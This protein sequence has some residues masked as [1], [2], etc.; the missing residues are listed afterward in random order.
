MEAGIQKMMTTEALNVEKPTEEKGLDPEVVFETKTV[1][2]QFYD[3]IKAN[4]Q[5]YND[6]Q[7]IEELFKRSGVVYQEGLQAKLPQTA[8]KY[9]NLVGSAFTILMRIF[10]A[11]HGM[12]PTSNVAPNQTQTPQKPLITL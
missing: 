10:L 1:L 4:P 12:V 7:L 9:F 11:K 8:E 5:K 6:K 2:E 3:E